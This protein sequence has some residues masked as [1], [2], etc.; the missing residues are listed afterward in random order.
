LSDSLGLKAVTMDQQ[1]FVD[2]RSP[3]PDGDQ[4]IDKRADELSVRRPNHF[5]RIAFFKGQQV[6]ENGPRPVEHDVVRSGV[7]QRKAGP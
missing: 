7:L 3:M 4:W 6:E 2:S 1:Q 5:Q